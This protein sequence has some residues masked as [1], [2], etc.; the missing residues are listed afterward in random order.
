MNEPTKLNSFIACKNDSLNIKTYVLNDTSDVDSINSAIDKLIFKNKACLKLGEESL[1]EIKGNNF[2]KS[3]NKA[4]D[5]SMQRIT[6]EN[7]LYAMIQKDYF[8]L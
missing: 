8:L 1:T 7:N 3:L 6:A 2:E 4:I 5:L